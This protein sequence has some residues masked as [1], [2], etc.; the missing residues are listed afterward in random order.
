MPNQFPPFLNNR[1]KTGC[2]NYEFND[3]YYLRMRCLLYKPHI[4]ETNILFI[5]DTIW[6]TFVDHSKSISE[7][8]K[9]RHV[10]TSV[11]WFSFSNLFFLIAS[12]LSVK[13]D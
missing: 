7:L 10:Y 12:T 4:Q 5:L 13:V 3:F 9:I 11:H 2:Q 1:M 8:R 6:L